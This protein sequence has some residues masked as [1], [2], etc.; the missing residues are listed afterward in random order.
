MAFALSQRENIS[1][2]KEL[3]SANCLFFSCFKLNVKGK[4]EVEEERDRQTVREREREKEGGGRKRESGREKERE[5]EGG[6]EREREVS[7][8][9]YPTRKVTT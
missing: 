5:R 6:R 2:C 9:F 8:K 1:I 7:S 4:R 3:V